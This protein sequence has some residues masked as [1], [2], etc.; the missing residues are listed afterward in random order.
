MQHQ[1]HFVNMHIKLTLMN[2]QHCVCNH[3]AKQQA[4]QQ[5]DLNYAIKASMHKMTMESMLLNV[6][7]EPQCETMMKQI[8]RG[9]GRDWV[10]GG[11]G[12]RG[13]GGS[14]AKGC[15]SAPCRYNGRSC[16]GS[17]S[18]AG[19]SKT[20]RTHGPHSTPTSAPST[21]ARHATLV[22]RLIQT[23]HTSHPCSC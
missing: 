15:T 20:P 21:A 4:M 1:K 7:V 11:L 23:L 12:E 22:S 2:Q 9:R 10:R 5:T 17:R 16:I 8:K 18:A 14:S 6:H 3:A 19:L 13:G